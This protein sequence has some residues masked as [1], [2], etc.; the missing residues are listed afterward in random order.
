[1]FILMEWRTEGSEEVT[2]RRMCPTCRKASDYVVPSTYIPSNDKEKAELLG[3]H[4]NKL[5]KIRCRNF[6]GLGTCLFGSDCFYAHL[7]EKGNDIKS[8]D[9]TMQE[10]YEER[11]RRKSRRCVDTDAI[12]EMLMTVLQ[13]DLY[14]GQ[15]G[16]A[17]NDRFERERSVL[18]RVFL[19]R[20]LWSGR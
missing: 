18:Q 8:F 5:A 12:L 1:M 20:I 11:K 17:D 3:N 7:D 16:Q 6:A 4:K 9:K 10:L 15:R 2:C 13:R 19:S 14:Q